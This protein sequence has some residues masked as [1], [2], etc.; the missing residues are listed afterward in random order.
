MR[1]TSDAPPRPRLA[2]R[3]GVTG[4]RTLSA[5]IRRDLHE[6]IAALLEHLRD[7]V[8]DIRKQNAA[9]YSTDPASLVLVSPLAR[10]ADRLV[11][12]RATALGFELDVP[13]PYDLTETDPRIADPETPAGKLYRSARARF[14]LDGLHGDV[15]SYV[16]V[17]RRVVWNSDLLIA[18]WDG[19]PAAGPGG[20]AEI[21]RLAREHDVPVVHFHTERVGTI[22]LYA[23]PDPVEAS[24]VEELFPRITRLLDLALVPPGSEDGAGGH[25][26][27]NLLHKYFEETPPWLVTRLLV[28]KTYATVTGLLG[29]PARIAFPSLPR[30][31]VEASRRAWREDW[32]KADVPSWLTNQVEDRLLG[33][34]AWANHLSIL[35]AIRYRSVFFWIYCLAVLAVGSAVAGHLHEVRAGKVRAAWM[36]ARCEAGQANAGTHECNVLGERLQTEKRAARGWS[37]WEFALLAIVLVLFL[38]GR[39]GKY[40]EK[41]VDYRSLAERIRHLTFLM[42][43]GSTSPAI[44]VPVPAQHAD[45]SSTWLNWL[46]RAIVRQAGLF[47]ARVDPT[48][49]AHCR[50]LLVDDVVRGQAGYHERISLRLSA[51]HRRLHRFTIL[52]FSV[53]FLV[54]LLHYWGIHWTKNAQL[55]F[56]LAVLLPAIA[57]AVHGFLSQGDFEN[58]AL[59][60]ESAHRQLTRLGDE[61][62]ALYLTTPSQRREMARAERRER[63]AALDG[64]ALRERAVRVVEDRLD[65]ESEPALGIAVPDLEQRQLEWRETVARLGDREL[66]DLLDRGPLA[67]FPAAASAELGRYARH[68]ADIMGDELIGW[69]ADSQVRPLVLA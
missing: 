54:S 33:H 37:G 63:L 27:S 26:A 44:R 56:A 29:L 21:V 9:V 34:F 38:R 6:G 3:V 42:P 61:V 32:S 58:V 51:V 18:I 20:T 31:C 7:T 15:Q 41:W 48:Y 22:T 49:L 13:T 69:R 45:P 5:A 16:E 59:R 64:D 40:H 17:G 50:S 62:S 52:L 57:A 46:F 30:H 14:V 66:R 55:S 10:G 8:L 23:G 65:A 36:A 39:L 24:S 68:A 67:E 4:H 47:D 60:A 1:Q 35:Y 19:R 53:A 12:R 43:L 2:Y 28:G 11:A 25:R